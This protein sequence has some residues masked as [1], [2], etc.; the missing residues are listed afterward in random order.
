MFSWPYPDDFFKLLSKLT[1]LDFSRTIRLNFTRFITSVNSLEGAP[2]K[3]L[4]LKNAQIIPDDT[5]NTYVQ[6]NYIRFFNLTEI[7]C[8]LNSLEELDLT[9]NA[10][11]SLTMDFQTECGMNLRVLDVRY[12]L[13]HG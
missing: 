2:L 11:V 8:S 9:Y 10:L 12:N 1:I 4:I 13:L 6:A 5:R 3:K 7:L